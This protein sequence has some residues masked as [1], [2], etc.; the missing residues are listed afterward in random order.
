MRYSLAIMIMMITSSLRVRGGW[1]AAPGHATRTEKLNEQL[2]RALGEQ[3]SFVRSGV[4]RIFISR[5]PDNVPPGNKQ[6]R[7]YRDH[8]SHDKRAQINGGDKK[9][10]I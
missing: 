8:T 9:I 6:E 1:S 2:C 7:E 4:K 5:H 3:S 10:I